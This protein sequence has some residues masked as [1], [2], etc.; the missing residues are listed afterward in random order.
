MAEE[1]TMAERLRQ[2]AEANSGNQ[3]VSL[4]EVTP[5]D[6]ETVESKSK[7]GA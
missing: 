2:A 6:S 1:L 3:E 4:P 5:I 7:S